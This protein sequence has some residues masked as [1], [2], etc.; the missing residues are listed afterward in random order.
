MDDIKSRLTGETPKIASKE[1][2]EMADI[3]GISL[4]ELYEG[5]YKTCSICLLPYT[6]H[7]HNARPVSDGLCC[8]ACDQSH[9]MTARLA[10][11]GMR[12]NEVGP[13][14]EIIRHANAIHAQLADF[15]QR[16]GQT[17][18]DASLRRFVEWRESQNQEQT[19]SE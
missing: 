2:V 17:P 4:D 8:S 16:T 13:A 19:D 10:T 18:S 14:L 6:G 12:E 15:L 11:L 5:D 7:G 1:D 3:C 9:V